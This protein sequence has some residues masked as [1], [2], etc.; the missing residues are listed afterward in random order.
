[1][2]ARR[3]GLAVPTAA[4]ACVFTLALALLVGTPRP[5]AT[6]FGVG[7]VTD[8]VH[9]AAM[10]AAQLGPAPPAAWPLPWP[11]GPMVRGVLAANLI[12]GAFGGVLA[13]LTLTRHGPSRRDGRSA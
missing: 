12:A 5:L 13:L 10:L 6:A 7:A 3:R 4:L 8:G 11:L 9:F 2:A 1:M